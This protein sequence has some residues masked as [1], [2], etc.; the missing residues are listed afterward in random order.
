MALKDGMLLLV[1]LPQIVLGNYP[2]ICTQTQLAFSKLVQGFS[3]I[4]EHPVD[5]R[6]G[7]ESTEI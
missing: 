4:L 7:E 3:N 5:F 1:K 6:L 2:Y